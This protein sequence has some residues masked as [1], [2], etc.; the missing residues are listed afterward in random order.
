MSM[1]AD[2]NEN[3]LPHRNIIQRPDPWDKQD[4]T[5][6]EYDA[7]RERRVNQKRAETKA[8]ALKAVLRAEKRIPQLKAEAKAYPA[9]IGRIAE[10]ILSLRNNSAQL[11]WE[12]KLATEAKPEENQPWHT[13]RFLSGVLL[14]ESDMQAA[15]ETTPPPVV[16]ATPGPHHI[17]LTQFEHRP[18]NQNAPVVG[19]KTVPQSPDIPRNRYQEVTEKELCA[20]AGTKFRGR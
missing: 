15:P 12:L 19:P 13:V 4:M 20:I 16:K 6:A 8:L 18:V 3:R 14:N 17:W 7:L 10:L 5:Q 1:F 2:L 11:K 9:R